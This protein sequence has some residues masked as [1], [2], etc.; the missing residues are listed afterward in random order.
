MLIQDRRGVVAMCLQMSQIVSDPFDRVF[1]PH[2]IVFELDSAALDKFSIFM[3]GVHHLLS[4]GIDDHLLG[5]QSFLEHPDFRF[6]VIDLMPEVFEWSRPASWSILIRRRVS[7][8]AK[9]NEC[10]P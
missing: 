7:R 1:E 3:I 4:E 6:M 10:D 5:V 2:D 9:K 8:G